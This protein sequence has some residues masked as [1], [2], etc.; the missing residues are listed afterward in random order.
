VL[1]D[2]RAV[3]RGSPEEMADYAERL[4]AAG[5]RV[6]GG[7]CGSAPVHLRAMADALGLSP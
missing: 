3:Y 1:E 6:V 4:V 2:G 7:C 5:V